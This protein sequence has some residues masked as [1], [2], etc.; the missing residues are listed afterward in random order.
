MAEQN[1]EEPKPPLAR[2]GARPFAGPAAGASGAARPFLRP[3]SPGQRPAPAPFAPRTVPPRSTLGTAVPAAPATM[4]AQ[5]TAPTPIEEPLAVPAVVASEADAIV[6][7]AEPASPSVV[8]SEAA[9]D[10]IDAFDA[11]WA[12]AGE[13]A[14]P[15]DTTDAAPTAAASPLDESSL[16]TLDAASI[17]SDE[18]TG[19]AEGIDSPTEVAPARP[20]AELDMPAWLADD[21]DPAPIEGVIE[22][23]DLALPD[24]AIL[25]DDALA[26]SRGPGHDA[27]EESAGPSPLIPRAA[28]A[29]VEQ[30]SP[31]VDEIA[32]GDH[33]PRFELVMEAEQT[34]G[35]SVGGQP[36]PSATR[37]VQVSAV[38]DRLA[39]QVRS[40]EI[41]VSSIAPDATDAAM[42]ASVL[43]ALLGGSGSR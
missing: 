30:P 43:V 41:D 29:A 15:P 7:P 31:A 3:T 5:S 12:S 40:G 18:I 16:G 32:L 6:V 8:A 35:P 17:W 27:A 33:R 24:A 20:P 1:S 2:R 23:Q 38:L 42:L 34:S 28:P 11:L 22:D 19:A 13:V 14:S 9:L 36:A 37:G 10:A 26:D 25:S 39:E 21:H 4:P